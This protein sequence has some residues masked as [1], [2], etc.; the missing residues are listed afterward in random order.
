M[1][2]DTG[3]STPGPVDIG[4]VALIS[5]V[6]M[7][8]ATRP[9]RRRRNRPVGVALAHERGS[10]VLPVARHLPPLPAGIGQ[11][12]LGQVPFREFPEPQPDRS[13]RS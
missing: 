6:V 11:H 5:P 7:P 1:I 8:L 13:P 3:P 4:E 9:A 12:R 10:K 2:R